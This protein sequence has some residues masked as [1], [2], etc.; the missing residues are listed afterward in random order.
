MPLGLHARIIVAPASVL[1]S[2]W[3]HDMANDLC[4]ARLELYRDFTARPR[5]IKLR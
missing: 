2:R 5:A 1:N 3:A 4:R